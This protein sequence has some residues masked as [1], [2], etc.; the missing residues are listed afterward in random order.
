ML[1]WLLKKQ[2][3]KQSAHSLGLSSLLHFY[4]N[5]L[6]E[7]FTL[8]FWECVHLATSFS[9]EVLHTFFVS[10]F[11]SI[12]GPQITGSSSNDNAYVHP[13][14]VQ[15]ALVCSFC[16]GSTH[17][18]LGFYFHFY[19]EKSEAKNWKSYPY[20]WSFTKKQNKMTQNKTKWNYQTPK[21][22]YQYNKNLK[23]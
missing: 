17:I 13:P 20:L 19:G 15:E 14:V 10:V 18:A 12:P 4:N 1:C 16:K 11:I 6:L 2:L 23:M 9:W 22:H 8:W 7:W 21:P 3:P 5:S